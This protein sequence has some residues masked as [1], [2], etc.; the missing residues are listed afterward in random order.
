MTPEQMKR[1]ALLFDKL[2]HGAG[3]LEVSEEDAEALWALRVAAEERGLVEPFS[4]PAISR[5]WDRQVIRSLR[6]LRGEEQLEVVFSAASDDLVHISGVPG[7]DEPGFGTARRGEWN[8]ACIQGPA[9]ST[10]QWS[11]SWQVIRDDGSE[12]L[13]VH[14]IYDGCWTF[15]VGRLDEDKPLPGWRWELREGDRPYALELRITAP[16]DALVE[17]LFEAEPED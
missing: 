14:A 6:A 4:D 5:G 7:A 16:A 3:T 9:K 17:P 13:R 15:A 1:V 8:V 12:G 11:G 2:E 10:A